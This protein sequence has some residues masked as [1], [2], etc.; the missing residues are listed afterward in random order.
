MKMKGLADVITNLDDVRDELAA[1]AK[2]PEAK[3]GK[4]SAQLQRLL[5]AARSDITQALWKMSD[6]IS[7]VSE[8]PE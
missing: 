4:G 6:V 2:Q 7:L 3:V 1:L 5:V 8:K